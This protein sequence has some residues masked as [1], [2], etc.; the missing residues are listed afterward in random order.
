[1]PLAIS[2]G[3]IVVYRNKHYIFCSPSFRPCV[4][5]ADALFQRSVCYLRDKQ[6]CLNPETRQ[7]SADALRNLSTIVV[8]PQSVVRATFASRQRRIAVAVINK[9]YHFAHISVFKFVKVNVEMARG[10]VYE[11][12]L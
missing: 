4:H 1:M 5:L 3:S 6:D 7:L 9:N 12:L 2:S 10:L 8:F 11:Y